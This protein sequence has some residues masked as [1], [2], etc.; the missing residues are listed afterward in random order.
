MQENDTLKSNETDED[1]L[2]KAVEMVFN[3]VY[4]KIVPNKF[5]EDQNLMKF[6]E[7][8]QKA[9]SYITTPRN[10]SE[11]VH[12][13]SSRK[14][15]FVGCVFDDP[16]VLW[17]GKSRPVQRRKRHLEDGKK[18]ALVSQ[19]AS[20]QD[21]RRSRA[22]SVDHGVFSRPNMYASKKGPRWQ[23]NNSLSKSFIRNK[24]FQCLPIVPDITEVIVNRRRKS[25]Y[26]LYQ[27]CRKINLDH[28]WMMHWKLK[29]KKKVNKKYST[30]HILLR[31]LLKG[32][33]K[34]NS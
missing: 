30:R 14:N 4:I 1:S 9:I 5:F 19:R 22:K 34:K 24:N 18:Q 29:H 12:K 11:P 27:S 26:M 25:Q 2:K 6:D 13:I 7:K 16:T 28:L 15:S 10:C 8:F 31:M 3:E 23:R 32:R 21:G 33:N 20:K 17:G